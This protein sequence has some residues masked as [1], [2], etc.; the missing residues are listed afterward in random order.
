[1]SRMRRCLPCIALVACISLASFSV[2]AQAAPG[3]LSRVSPDAL[4][5]LVGA[6]FMAMLAGYAKGQERRITAVEIEQRQIQ[7]QIS[8][9]RETVLER[10]PTRPELTALAESMRDSFSEVKAMIREL[11]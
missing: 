9:F 7:A 11:R 3:P 6:L 2:Y 10:H 8:L 4:V 5:A 1:M